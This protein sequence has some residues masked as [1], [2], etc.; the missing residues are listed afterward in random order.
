MSS[1]QDLKR[2][3]EFLE[4]MD[5]RLMKNRKLILDELARRAEPKPPPP[6]V[7]DIVPMPTVMPSEKN[8]VVK[9]KVKVPVEV[10][11][12]VA[13]PVDD[14]KEGTGSSP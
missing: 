3:H 10:P 13:V 8:R 14:A 6:K 2:K 11:V 12:K 9:R 4:Y 7:L 5:R 1:V